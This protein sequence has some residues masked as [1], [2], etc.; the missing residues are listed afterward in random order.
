MKSFEKAF[1]HE[2][3]RDKL[4]KK[5]TCIETEIIFQKKPKISWFHKGDVWIKCIYNER[6]LGERVCAMRGHERLQ[7]KLLRD[8]RIEE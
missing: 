4:P 8:M 5:V 2:R 1:F 6:T 7:Y 3:V